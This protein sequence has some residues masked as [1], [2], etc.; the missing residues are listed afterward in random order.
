[1]RHRAIHLLFAP[2]TLLSTA[3]AQDTAPQ[4]VIEAQIQGMAKGDTVYLANY[5][6]SKLYYNDTAYVDAKS[7]AVFKKPRGYD[8]GVYAVVVPGPKYFELVVNER[9][10]KVATRMDDLLPGLQIK[11]SK[12]NELFIGYIRFL[13]DR[14][15]EGDALRA[16]MDAAKDADARAAVK[17]R[18]EE[19]DQR[20]K[21]YQRDLV[22]NNKSTLAASLVKMSMAVELP[23]ARKA[24][25]TLD[26]AAAYYQYRKHF[27][28]NFDLTDDRIVRVP[29]FGNKF[30]E[31]MTKV[32]P[33]IPDTIT[34][35]ADELIAR[36]GNAKETFKYVVHNVTH[37]FE[38]SDIMGMDAVFVHM[39]LTYYCPK[40]SQ[41]SR[42]DWMSAGK[43]DT[44]CTRAKKM[45]PLT[46]GRKAPY[47]SLTD[48]TEQRW[49]NYYELPQDY[50]VIIFWDPNCG[51]CKKELPEIH[52][53]YKEKLKPMGIEV[54][55][56]AK[57]VEDKM[58]DDWRKFI[59]ENKL[60]WVNVGL[61]PTIFSEARK[62]AR[63]YIP[64]Y[65]TIESLNYADAWD[66]FSTPKV[67]LVDAE[68][69][70]A[71]KSLSAD[72]I[73]DLVGKL[74]ERKAK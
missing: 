45:A 46:I 48:T 64:Q 40:P 53:V 73:A 32:V 56:V 72:Q 24:D 50:V 39:A 62:D 30:E 34:R 37:K 15:I 70:I 54:F 43:I 52:K 26:S 22:M 33:Q 17:A 14:K 61:T 51:H 41:P 9:V 6:G 20:V 58:F 68:R 38:T 36:T 3:A 44:L 55:A 4:R 11:Q 35:L 67:F 29:V 71:G 59:R 7:N 1:M 63:K 27:W 47:L 60:E 21:Q 74:R 31:Y 25:G 5:Y 19:L 2:L 28:D 18:M 23:E 69:R 10:I 8:A 65:T 16:Q 13:N 42:V 57:A 49:L 12:E 66:V